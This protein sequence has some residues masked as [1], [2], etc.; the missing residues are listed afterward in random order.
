MA[1][2]IGCARLIA[3]ERRVVLVGLVGVRDGES[4]STGLCRRVTCARG[5]VGWQTASER[6]AKPRTRLTHA[7]G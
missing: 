3:G 2:R 7:L 5:Y 6:A 4:L 1:M